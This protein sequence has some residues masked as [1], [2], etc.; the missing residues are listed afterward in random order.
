M[1]NPYSNEVKRY[2]KERPLFVRTSL[3][4]LVA[5]TDEEV[6]P[7]GLPVPFDTLRVMFDVWIPE[8]AS[9]FSPSVLK[10]CAYIPPDGL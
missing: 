5:S 4:L 10:R 1:S 9:S 6:L 3:M 2:F 7:S 8:P